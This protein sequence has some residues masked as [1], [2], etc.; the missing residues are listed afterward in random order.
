M[1]L[2]S[3]IL[4]A[5]LLS[6]GLLIFYVDYADSLPSTY[7]DAHYGRDGLPRRRRGGG[8]R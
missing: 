8:T 1:K 2:L 4:L 7:S 3:S 6:S 5:L